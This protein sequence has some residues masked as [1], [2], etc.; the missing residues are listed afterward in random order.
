MVKVLERSGTQET[1]LNIIKSIY[2]KPI[3]NVKVNEE[4]I[5][6]LH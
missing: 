5:K 3:T 6:Q 2:S 1:Y 4:K